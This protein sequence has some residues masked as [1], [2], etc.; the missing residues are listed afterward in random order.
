ML[1]LPTLGS[2]IALPVHLYKRAY[3]VSNF[4]TETNAVVS[5]LNCLSETVRMRA[6]KVNILNSKRNAKICSF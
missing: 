5:R 3:S 4:Y 6:Y 2:A 1:T